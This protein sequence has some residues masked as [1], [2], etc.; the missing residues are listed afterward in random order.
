MMR[1]MS[2]RSSMIWAWAWEFRSM[3]AS[4]SARSSASTLPERRILA[5]PTMALSGVRSSCDSVA[6]N[7]SFMRLAASASALA[8]SAAASSRSRSA[9]ARLRSVM[10]R[11]TFA[12]PIIVPSASRIGETLSETSMIRPS[13]VSRWVSK[14]PTARPAGY[15]P[16]SGHVLG[17][18][19]RHQGGDGLADDLGGGVAQDPLGGLIPARDDPVERLADDGVVGGFDDG[20]QHQLVSSACRRATSAV[21]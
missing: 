11:A 7:S 6:R 15:A 13:F 4:P 18:L 3:A 19:R 14:W 17:M 9:S 8:D 10:S 5:Q 20:R 1:E 21:C 12:A 16:G 2:S